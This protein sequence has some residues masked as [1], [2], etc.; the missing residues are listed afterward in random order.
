MHIH[1]RHDLTYHSKDVP[2]TCL[3]QY[4][5]RDGKLNAV[6]YMRSNDIILGTAY[7]VFVFTMLQEYIAN[8]LGVDM[9]AYTHVAGSLHIYEK[10]F[11]FIES[12]QNSTVL[13]GNI[14]TMP[15]MPMDGF[16]DAMTLFK[17]ITSRDW[18]IEDNLANNIAF[19]DNMRR[20]YWKDIC[21]LMLVKII[22][23][24]AISHPISD[25][26]D[27]LVR[28]IIDEIDYYGYHKLK[29]VDNAS[30]S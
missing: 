3:L 21:R 13:V 14:L 25:S 7:D 23:K 18:S 4:F 2:C 22:R 6:T 16:E 30:S 10:N 1:D 11:D 26:I 19:I 15:D 17:D 5:I 9:G 24:Y 20:A 29:G 28:G 27:S 12:A 8:A